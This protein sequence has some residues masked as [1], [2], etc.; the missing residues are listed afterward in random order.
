MTRIKD[1]CID[2]LL[3]VRHEMN[4]QR[5][6]NVFELFGFDFLLDEDC[7]VWLIECNTNPYLGTPCAYMKQMLPQ[8]MNDLFKICVD[9]V[10]APRTVPDA[11]RENNFE[12]IYKETFDALGP[13]VNKRR[14]F[15]LDLCYPIPTLKPFIG[16]TNLHL[17]R[18]EVKETLIKKEA[19]EDPRYLEHASSGHHIVG[20]TRSRSIWSHPARKSL[21]RFKKKQTGSGEPS[22]ER[23]ASTGHRRNTLVE[24]GQALIN[25]RNSHK[26]FGDKIPE[27]DE[28]DKDSDLS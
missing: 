10:F 9:P 17:R 23:Q 18:I 27:L 6:T 25:R 20:E 12:L 26:S 1:M 5:R 8:M 21:T 19:L 4:P 2:T 7:R 13:P 22:I 16:K 14:P 28:E 3:S 15:H 24:V 11:S